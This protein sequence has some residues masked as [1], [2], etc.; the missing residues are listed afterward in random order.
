LSEQVAKLA[1]VKGIFRIKIELSKAAAN[2][3]ELPP[4]DWM[5]RAKAKMTSVKDAGEIVNYVTHESTLNQCWQKLREADESV[6]NR[7]ISIVLAEG[8]PNLSG[9]TI[10]KSEDSK[11]LIELGIQASSDVVKEW[12]LESFMSYVNFEVKKYYPDL[13]VNQGQV[14]AAY[15]RASQG[16][17]VH[18]ALLSAQPGLGD[19]DNKAV[20]MIGNKAKKEVYMVIRDLRELAD[21]AKLEQIMGSLKGACERV[22]KEHGA[23]YR[24]LNVSVRAAIENVIQGPESLGVDLPVVILGGLVIESLSKEKLPQNVP[25]YPGIGKLELIIDDDKMTAHISKFSM[26][27]YD[28]ASMKL[29]QYWLIKE[30]KR[31][32]IAENAFKPY[33]RG[34][35]ERMNKKEDLN[36]IMVAKGTDPIPGS[37]PYL[38]ETYKQA[39]VEGINLDTDTLDMRSIQKQNIVTAGKII[40][41]VRYKKE[42]VFGSDIYGNRMI[43]GKSEG[44]NIIVGDTV[45]ERNGKYY[46]KIDGMPLIEDHK[47][48]S[49]SSIL[50]HKGDVNLRSGHIVFDGP[51]RIEGS[52]DNGAVVRANGDVFIKG[53]V[54]GAVVISSRNIEILGGVIT[55]EK[56]KVSAMGDVKAEFC[57][58][59]TISCGGNLFVKKAI[60]NSRL[61]VGQS[62]EVMSREDGIVAGGLISCSKMLKTANLGFKNGTKTHLNIGVDWKAEVSFRLKE[63]RYED[64]VSNQTQDRLSLRELTSKRNEQ[65]TPKHQE[66][67]IYYQKRLQRIRTVIEKA[68]EQME[69]AKTKLTYNVGAQILV[70]KFLF[71]NTDIRISGQQINL[72]QDLIGVAILAKKRRGSHILSI[73]EL[74]EAEAS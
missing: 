11:Y 32:N 40:A 54:R 28:D 63:K 6:A 42:P 18:Q 9:I 47:K 48:I 51:V 62:I 45:E 8:I 38:F 67:K 20:S 55:G 49:I 3:S 53:T 13:K 2:Q 26:D 1:Y 14:V 41:E 16:C 69:K 74:N 7:S 60:L 37:Q 31:Q 50:V 15:H 10:K 70:N 30:L 29:D 23:G 68:T 59:S 39:S 27:L 65:M 58:N 17:Q 22:L 12:R 66:K 73:E 46:A 61:T 4:E 33:L 64:L 5:L 21:P 43:P 24:F 34:V 35:L 56:G 44:I 25:S 71:S 19:E 36:E 57:E 72:V 52:V